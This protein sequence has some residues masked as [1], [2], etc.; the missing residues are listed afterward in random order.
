MTENFIL[1][2]IYLKIFLGIFYAYFC[3][4]DS[5]HL[6]QMFFKEIEMFKKMKKKGAPVHKI[7]VLKNF[8]G[9]EIFIVKHKFI[10]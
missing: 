9:D 1:Y 4:S 8:G 10:K 6:K 7:C 3:H 5:K 2:C